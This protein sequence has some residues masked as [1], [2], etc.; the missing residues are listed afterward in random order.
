MIFATKNDKRRHCAASN[1]R[2]AK[3]IVYKLTWTLQSGRSHKYWFFVAA[4]A[5]AD[6]V[7]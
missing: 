7:V 1:E 5:A 3:T 4:A 6:L 2:S